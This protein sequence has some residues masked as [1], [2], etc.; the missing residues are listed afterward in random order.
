MGRLAGKTAF[1]TG[2]ASGIGREIAKQFAQEGAVLVLADIDTDGLRQTASAIGTSTLQ[3]SL[4]VTSEEAWRQAA[5]AVRSQVESL[6]IVVNSAGIS[7]DL[8]NIEDCSFSLWNQIVSVNLSGTF[9]GCQMAVDLMKATGGG[10]IINI[11]SVRSIVASP[12]TL[13]YST[14][15]SGVL[16]LTKS[17]ALHCAK[18]NYNIR[19][20]AICPGAIT[21]AMHE[22][23]LTRETDPDAALQEWVSEYP[24]GRLG[25]AQDVAMMAIYLA[26][27][28]SSF[29]T[30]AHFMVDG[31]FTA[32]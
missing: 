7:P 1:I 18:K 22:D 5:N 8:D 3:V 12:I 26:S 2:A 21:T 31:G 25:T 23:M 10:S 15:K 24:V 11:G 17:V 13:A 29:V 27:D 19:A 6:D 16:G 4:N 32:Q 20:N 9:L 28:D 14:T 30:G